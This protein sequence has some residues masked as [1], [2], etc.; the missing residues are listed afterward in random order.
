MS[1]LNL[2]SHSQ[3]T[4]VANIPP[5]FV[6]GLLDGHQDKQRKQSMYSIAKTIRLPATFVELRHQSTHEQLPSLAKLRTAAR[7]ALLWIWHYYWKH[8]GEHGSDPCREVVLKYL[9]EG[10]SVKAKRMVDELERWPRDRV[11]K[12][13]D[14]V[15]GSLPGNQAFIKCAELAERLKKGGEGRKD[16]GVTD[17]AM[18]GASVGQDIKDEEEDFGWTRF[19][20]TWKTK[21]IGIV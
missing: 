16:D 12:T 15:K 20:G 2:F 3:H 19:Q 8:L 7:K 1:Y 4:V 21:P 17:T 9:R 6:T 14:E 10:D 11:A 5:S 18:G 13:V